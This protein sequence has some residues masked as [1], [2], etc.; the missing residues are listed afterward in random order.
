MEN[1]I[2]S[3]CSRQD[4]EH[5]GGE[6]LVNPEVCWDL[7]RP[8]SQ[9][10]WSRATPSGRSG[11]FPLTSAA[12]DEDEDGGE[13]PRRCSLSRMRAEKL[14][15]APCE[16]PGL[17]NI[18]LGRRSRPDR[19]EP[20]AARSHRSC[21]SPPRERLWE[22]GRNPEDGRCSAAPLLAASGSNPPQ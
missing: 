18:P 2:N 3:N 10:I 19:L 8:G 5:S 4:A 16:K 20:P 1:Q 14:R 11:R 13:E 22:R 9:N 12:E 15:A 21:L 17:T 6:M 7:N